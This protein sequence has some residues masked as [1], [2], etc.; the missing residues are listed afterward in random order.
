[1]WNDMSKWMEAATF[2]DWFWHILAVGACVVVCVPQLTWP[3]I[4]RWF[5]IGENQENEQ[6]ESPE[7]E[8]PSLPK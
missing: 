5:K 8:D 4:Q 3:Y 6:T 1:M 7:F 2:W